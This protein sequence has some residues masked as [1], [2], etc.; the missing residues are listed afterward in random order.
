[1]C[2]SET[3]ED[4]KATESN[5]HY[6]QQSTRLKSPPNTKRT[7]HQIHSTQNPVGTSNGDE[8]N[9]HVG[10]EDDRMS[11]LYL[12][13]SKL[14]YGSCRMRQRQQRH[15]ERRHSPCFCSDRGKRGFK[16]K[17]DRNDVSHG[18]TLWCVWKVISQSLFAFVESVFSGRRYLTQPHKCRVRKRRDNVQGQSSNW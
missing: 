18:C 1:M 2:A 10:R 12:N 9:G 4:Q 6:I 11:L 5:S 17:H 3:E 7:S 16:N 14:N 15:R 8:I 13:V